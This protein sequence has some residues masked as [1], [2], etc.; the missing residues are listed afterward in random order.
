MTDKYTPTTA[1]IINGYAKANCGDGSR[2]DPEE[3]EME[4]RFDALRWLTAHDREVAAKA[5]REAAENFKHCPDYKSRATRWWATE[6]YLNNRA[7]A[8]ESG[9]RFST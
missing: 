7:D 2:G 3:F 6:D 5:L 4:N 1:E 9:E 8:I